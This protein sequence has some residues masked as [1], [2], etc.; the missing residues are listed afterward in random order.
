MCYKNSKD[1]ESVKKLFEFALEFATKNSFSWTWLGV[2]EHNTK[3]QAFITDM[4]LRNLANIIL[5]LVKSRY[6][7]VTEKEIKVRREFFY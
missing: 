2:W 7:L 5:W 1:L 3:A 6:R 4:V